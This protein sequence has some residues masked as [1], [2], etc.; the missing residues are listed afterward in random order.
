M[1]WAKVSSRWQERQRERAGAAEREVQDTALAS[2]RGSAAT[3]CHLRGCHQMEEPS[4]CSLPIPAASAPGPA[5]PQR[6]GTGECT[7]EQ[8]GCSSLL[9]NGKK[10]IL[11]IVC[12]PW[13]WGGGGEREVPNVPAWWGAL[14]ELLCVME[15]TENAWNTSTNAR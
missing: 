1:Q 8:Q 3:A 4:C 7:G 12:V 14:L 15:Q 6:C 9:E 10:L 2:A 13:P 5:S 11:W